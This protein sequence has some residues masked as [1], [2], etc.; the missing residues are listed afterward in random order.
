M[1][2]ARAAGEMVNQLTAL[3]ARRI[4]GEAASEPA[5]YLG[6]AGVQRWRELRAADAH[7]Q[8]ELG[9]KLQQIAEEGAEF[10][11][12]LLVWSDTLAALERAFKRGILNAFD[13]RVALRLSESD[14]NNLLGTPLA[15]RMDDNRALFRHEDWESG[16][17]EKFKPYA[18]PDAEVLEALLSR[19]RKG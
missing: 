16:R 4:S 12:H 1:I 9:K 14:S 15:A 18:I 5:T 6:I 8:T 11:I 13:L 2:G 3:L 7:G 17:I 19:L 10:G